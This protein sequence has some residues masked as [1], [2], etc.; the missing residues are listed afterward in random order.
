MADG[1]IQ[2]EVIYDETVAGT[3]AE[4]SHQRY[5]ADYAVSV[6]TAEVG[7]LRREKF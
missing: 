1:S 7:V 3:I 4:N 6:F 5:F 2:R